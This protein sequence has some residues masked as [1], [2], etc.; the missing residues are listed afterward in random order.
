MVLRKNTETTPSKDFTVA[1]AS[2]I[3]NALHPRQSHDGISLRVLYIWIVIA[4]FIVSGLI[5]YSTYSLTS[6]FGQLTEATESQI[7]L[8][9]AAHELMD[10]SDYL[11]ER[12]QRFTVDGD[13]R[14]MEEYFTEAFET[15]RREN[16]IARMSNAPGN[17]D[18][19]AQLQQAMDGSV[20]LMKKEYYAM[21][22]VIEAK[23][24]TDYPETLKDIELT[25]ED[26]A[27]SARD[28]MRRATEM[29]LG[30][31]YYVEK[32]RIRME[33][34]QSLDVLEAL[35][36]NTESVAF[37]R[38]RERMAFVR[39]VL[40]LQILGTLLLVLLTLRLGITPI[41][42]AV[43]RIK[44]DRQ[45]RVRG[46]REFRYL[47]R[48]YNQL[49]IQL[50]EEN[51]LLKEASQTDALTG[52]QNRMA[53]RKHYDSY[54]GHEVSVMLL[55]LDEFKMINDTYGHE[56]GDR[57]LSETGK[58]LANVFGKECCYRYGG[59][60]F[61]VIL[62]DRS[63]AE[64]VRKM[65]AVM[66][67]R[68][69]LEL[70][71]EFLTVGYS[72]GYVHA[73]LDEK[74]DLRGLFSEADQ[75]MYQIKR[76]KLRTE[77][78][79][80]RRTHYDDAAIKA[81]VYTTEEMKEMLDT[82]TGMYDLARV[83]DPIECRILEFDSD[84]KIS[85]KERCYGIWNAEQKCVNCTSALACRTGCHQEK[86]E[87]FKDQLYHIQSNP[88]QL[89][90]SDGSAYDAVVELVSIDKNGRDAHAANDRAAE[91]KNNRAAQY[92]AQHDNLTKVLNA[93]A[94]SELSREAIARHGEMPWIMITSNI[95]D[96]RLVNTL[97]GTQRGNEIIVRNAEEMQ[98]IAANTNGLCGRIGGDRFAVLMPKGMYR[99][100]ML[101]RMAQS[102]KEDYSSG[103]YTFCIH[104]G[105]YE[106]EN[107]S[108]P[109]S[110]MCDR[111]NMALRTIREDHRQTV[112][113]FTSEMMNKS[114]FEQ[115]IIS[116]FDSALSEGQFHMY[117]QPLADED[118]NIIAAEALVRWHRPD[119]TVTMPGDFIETLERAGLIHKL[120]MYI[121]ESAVKQLSAWS[122]TC[123]ERIPI[124]VNMSARDF[125][126]VDVYA[127]LTE[128]IDRYHIASNRLRVEITETALLEDP[129]SGNEVISR[130]RR[131][132]FVV[133]IDDFGKGYS[134]LGL[135]KDIHADVL[136]ID[137][138]LM[139]EIESKQR[140]RK[141]LA[142]IIQMATSLGM[143]VVTEGVETQKQLESLKAMGCHHFQGYYFSRPIPVEAFES[144]YMSE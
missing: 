129:D 31:Q 23:G 133:E 1:D 26:A 13:P 128:L 123:M 140:S 32:D 98:R 42:K 118:G 121:W 46:A 84:G 119:G 126:A 45:I 78:V 81:A 124:S 88:V 120:D 95:M 9:K 91:N 24:Y 106:V 65:N 79:Q 64:F 111:A 110:V 63:E 86:T 117:L 36:R 56:E 44:A 85:R 73:M 30:D 6:T 101:V 69:V 53:L 4:A 116:G 54:K 20:E 48:A 144:K 112:A 10:A 52:I 19:L 18:A 70:D 29:V 28:K 104:F 60:E 5:F 11:T 139:R 76:D 75:K 7:A 125:Y 89:R 135:L 130:L 47:A 37:E 143:D 100:T 80:G 108:I 105:V 51:E 12:V 90:L 59:D 14:F 3:K 83:V 113:Y 115:E 62:P 99:E 21:R 107:P 33:M 93:S 50:G 40:I 66:S 57:V 16:A 134:S 35:T 68:P 109:I 137:M 138:S 114:L 17:A 136:K 74:R 58:L 71:G 2:D 132:G 43:E 87:S 96:Y 8:D 131:K 127:A 25:A 77:A 34:R 97:F 141:I 41:L 38:L 27:L 15:N 22:L 49:T 82:M 103:I 72:A 55:D 102:M 67:S 94:F 39:A 142:S 61:L 92:H 122:G